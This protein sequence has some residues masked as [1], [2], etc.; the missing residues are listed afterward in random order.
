MNRAMLQVYCAGAFSR[1][2]HGT[3]A[4]NID[5]AAKVAD[6][7]YSAGAWPVC[8]HT[9]G[10][11]WAGVWEQQRCLDGTLEQMRRCDAVVMVHNW[12]HSAGAKHENWVAQFECELPVFYA[13]PD[14]SLPDEFFAWLEEKDGTVAA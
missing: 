5:A 2:P 7:V 6:A 8:P 12:P 10:E 13:L 14:G 1:N 9:M 3:V 4:E 11:R